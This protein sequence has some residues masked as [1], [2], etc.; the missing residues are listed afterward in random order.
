MT[1]KTETTIFKNEIVIPQFDIEKIEISSTLGR[2]T[3]GDFNILTL[4]I[5]FHRRFEYYLTHNYIPAVLVVII[6]W[7]SF[8][9]DRDCAPARVGMGIT[10]ILTMTTLLIGAGQ[11]GL[12]VV[13]YIKAL[14]WYNIGCFIFV[15]VGLC[16]YSI[17]NY[18]S[19]KH[20]RMLNLQQLKRASYD[21]EKVKEEI[22]SPNCLDNYGIDYGSEDPGFYTSR[23]ASDAPEVKDESRE[24]CMSMLQISD[25]IENLLRILYPVLFLIFNIVYWL[26]F[27]KLR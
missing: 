13:S 14:D 16:E 27:R 26:T 15:F 22:Q 9:V 7:L 2:Y 5:H 8:F 1:N 21:L 25:N 17:V 18:F 4:R 24:M 19:T 10:T 20:I 3:V 23:C 12:P 11:Q 6:S